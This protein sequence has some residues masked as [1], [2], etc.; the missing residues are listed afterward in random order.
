[1]STISG[2]MMDRLIDKG[3]E[4]ERSRLFPNWVDVN[5]IRPL[6]HISTFRAKL[7]IPPTAVVALFS[8]TLS[9]KQG[10]MV[11]PAAARLLN[12]RLDIHFVICGDGVM[13]PELEAACKGMDR[14]HLLPL[15]DGALLPELL[16]LADIHLLPQSPD[17]EDLVLP[18]KLT[19]MLSSG[20]PIIATCNQ[21]TE[22]AS[23][24]SQCGL[25]VP[26]EN[27]QELARAIQQLADA[28]DARAL[29][30]KAARQYAE[31]TIGREAVLRGIERYMAAL[32][33]Q[34]APAAQE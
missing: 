21:Q 18:S 12:E 30:G 13:K 5:R 15:Q 2:R 22:I 3:I 31:D 17:A 4:P 8:G 20:R 14:V 16:G 34:Y 23:V 6:T 24:V 32:V 29:H 26:P 10:L 1:V 33:N 11:I 28:P 9:G 19:G 25:V 7:G 27:A